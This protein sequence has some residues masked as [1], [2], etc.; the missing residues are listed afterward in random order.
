MEIKNKREDLFTQNLP[1]VVTKPFMDLLI[2]IEAD[3]ESA[4]TQ[5]K[6]FSG[7]QPNEYDLIMVCSET[8]SDLI[9]TGVLPAAYLTTTAHKYLVF[10]LSE[11]G[12]KF[13][14]SYYKNGYWQF[15]TNMI[16]N[17]GLRVYGIKF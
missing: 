4:V 16:W 14:I 10:P 1:P 12:T 3:P 13:S 17:K 6:K 8:Q 5:R 9:S 11:G 15:S 7:L 2:S